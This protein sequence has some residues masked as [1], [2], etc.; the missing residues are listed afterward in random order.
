MV[1]FIHRPEYYKIYTD[2][3]GRD[4]RGMAEIIIA[5]HRNGAVGDVLLSFKGQFT[6]FQDRD[7]AY[8]P[9]PGEEFSS[10]MNTHAPAYP[11]A[12]AMDEP[13]GLQPPPFG[14]LPY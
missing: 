4:L 7:E 3:Q 10:T 13:L 5:K 11:N 8:I 12:P 14:D 9:V 2:S 1:C 6:R